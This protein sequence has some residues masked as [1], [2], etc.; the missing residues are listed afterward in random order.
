[1][2][3]PRQ[4][5]PGARMASVHEIVRVVENQKLLGNPATVN[6]DAR[7]GNSAYAFQPAEVLFHRI[8]ARDEVLVRLEGI[9]RK[10]HDDR[11]AICQ[12]AKIE[13]CPCWEIP[14]HVA[15]TRSFARGTYDRRKEQTIDMW[16]EF[17]PWG[18]RRFCAID[19]T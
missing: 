1:M 19:Y 5:P 18:P 9:R 10:G 13:N 6:T 7:L 14:T 11:K 17:G 12:K 3:S 4:M 8:G 15:V 16:A 2:N